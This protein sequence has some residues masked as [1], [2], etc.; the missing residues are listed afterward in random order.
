MDDADPPLT[1]SRLADLLDAEGYAPD[2]YGIGRHGK[3]RDQ[4]FVLDRWGNHWV[5]NY[6]ERGG[7]PEIRKHASEDAAC[8]DLLVRLNRSRSDEAAKPAD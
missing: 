6:T 3:Y 2:S 5:V 8:R 1:C 4:V 7:K